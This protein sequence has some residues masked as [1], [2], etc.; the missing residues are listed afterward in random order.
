MARPSLRSPFRRGP[1]AVAEGA[2]G[3][4][5]EPPAAPVP[6]PE[7]PVPAGRQRR[8]PYHPGALRRER[9]ALIRARE[10]RIRDL[11]GLMLE[12]YR[13]D[14]FRE[15]LLREQ[16]AEVVSME[17]RL[18]ELDTML[19]SARQQVQASR[20]ACGAPLLWGSHFCPNCGRPAGDAVVT[21]HNCG[22]ALPADAKFCGSCGAAAPVSPPAYEAVPPAAEEPRADSGAPAEPP[23]PEERPADSWER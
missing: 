9:K 1:G 12:M 4:P 23:H 18:Q 15:D 7:T 21:C 3:A 2:E 11:G 5:G 6:T 20:C 16:C 19:A 10:E 17:V 14:R 8:P 13:R 22:H